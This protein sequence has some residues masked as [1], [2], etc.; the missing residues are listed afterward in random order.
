MDQRAPCPIFDIVHPLFARP[1]SSS[2]AFYFA[3][4]D[5]FGKNSMS[6][7]ISKPYEFTASQ[8]QA[9]APASLPCRHLL[10][11]TFIGFTKSWGVSY[12]I[13]I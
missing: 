13:L 8:L 12:C 3:L 10:G 7:D 1:A 6:I 2:F 9:E 11:N 4:E 5:G